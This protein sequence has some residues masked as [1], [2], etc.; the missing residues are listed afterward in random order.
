MQTK[1][2]WPAKELSPNGHKARNKNGW[3]VPNPE[4]SLSDADE[5]RR[6]FVYEQETGLFFRRIT[7]GQRAKA[8][9]L[10][11]Y[12]NDGRK[13]IPFRCKKVNASRLA[14]LY[15]TGSWPRH[16]IDHINGIKDDDRFKNLRD[17]DRS[18]NLEN[19]R[20][21]RADNKSGVIGV[22]ERSGRFEPRLMVKGK[23]LYLGRYD[24]LEEARNVYIS[25]K[26]KLQQG[27][28]I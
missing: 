19:L 20:R 27:C 12:M 17:V 6:I 8:G 9:S 28:T 25:Q 5:V 24:T 26:R 22:R 23:P 2:P 1:L 10:A 18:T 15:V 4:S 3:L 11:G 21:A 13:V 14:W 7:I 16:E